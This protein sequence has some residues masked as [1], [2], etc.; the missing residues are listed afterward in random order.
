MCQ[1]VFV[2]RQDIDA[3]FGKWTNSKY[4]QEEEKKIVGGGVEA[5]LMKIIKTI[6]PTSNI[7]GLK[8][9]CFCQKVTSSGR[10][11][12]A[13]FLQILLCRS[14]SGC[15]ITAIFQVVR[16]LQIYTYGKGA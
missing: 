16:G 5:S 7:K 12:K 13:A 4:F 3:Q 10:C 8:L 2:W 1:R 14:I 9:N 15:K 11:Q 6:I